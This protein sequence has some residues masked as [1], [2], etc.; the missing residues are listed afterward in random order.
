MTL[1]V[2][3]MKSPL[4]MLLIVSGGDEVFALT[5]EDHEQRALAQLRRRHKDV[6]LASG[7][8]PAALRGALA[9]YFD[10]EIGA[11]T[12]IRVQTGG[13]PFQQ[14]VWS[15]LREIPVGSTT[16]Y[17]RLARTIGRPSAVRAVGLANGANPVAIVVPC[18]RVIGEDGSLTGYGGGLERKR[19]LLAHEGALPELCFGSKHAPSPTKVA[20][21]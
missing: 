3:R 16:S 5:F 8:S 2:D 11:L 9:S 13:T 4:G 6:T 20:S 18:H 12:A 14:A 19:W 21:P 17:S 1:T 15:A 10:G 7:A